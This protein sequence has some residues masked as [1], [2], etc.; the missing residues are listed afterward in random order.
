M[1][2]IRNLLTN[3]RT[4]LCCVR[5]T[6]GYALIFLW[7]IFSG[8]QAAGSGDSIPGPPEDLTLEM[9]IR[10]IMNGLLW[11]YLGDYKLEDGAISPRH[12]ESLQ[13]Y[14]CPGYSG[15][16]SLRN[17]SQTYLKEDGTKLINRAIRT[18]CGPKKVFCLLAK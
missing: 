8:C 2:T 10:G 6:L 13:V 1:N 17:T 5:E 16:K 11:P 18:W 14:H 7:A 15:I 3:L 12:L 4:L 9:K